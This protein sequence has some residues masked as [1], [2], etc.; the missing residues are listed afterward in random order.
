[1]QKLA[2][3]ALATFQGAYRFLDG[4]FVLIDVMYGVPSILTMTDAA[5][6][7]VRAIFPRTDREFFV[8][9]ALFIA[10]PV[11]TTLTFES[12]GERVV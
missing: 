1:M 4:K 3:D 12:N 9:P 8:G 6:G 7:E 11:T 5:T 10:S 2:P